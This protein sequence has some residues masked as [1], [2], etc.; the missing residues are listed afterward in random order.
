MKSTEKNQMV[1]NAKNHIKPVVE[2]QHVLLVIP[3][4]TYSDGTDTESEVL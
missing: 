1:S 3:L 4:V 2:T